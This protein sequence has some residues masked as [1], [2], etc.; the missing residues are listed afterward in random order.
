MA[1]PA[2]QV[3]AVV[4]NTRRVRRYKCMNPAPFVRDLSCTELEQDVFQDRMFN[5]AMVRGHAVKGRSSALQQLR[6]GAP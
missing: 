6:H 1:T 4:S 3:S 5:G 2:A